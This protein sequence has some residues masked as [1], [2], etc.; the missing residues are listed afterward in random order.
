MHPTMRWLEN[1]VNAVATWTWT[2]T[3]TAMGAYGADRPKATLLWGN[4]H[5]QNKLHRDLAGA[6]SSFMAAPEAGVTKVG[7]KDGKPTVSGGDN[8]KRT[9]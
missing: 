5:W 3:S 9:Q 8:L 2:E 4:R 1:V 7:V 6:S